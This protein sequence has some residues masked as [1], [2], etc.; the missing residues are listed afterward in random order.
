MKHEQAPLN[1]APNNGKKR[2]KERGPEP[3]PKEQ[4]LK[5][6]IK[7]H[8][9]KSCFRAPISMKKGWKTLISIKPKK[10]LTCNNNVLQDRGNPSFLQ[11]Y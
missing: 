1:K 11:C 10:A 5:W 3:K 2:N 8:W 4:N 9:N 7:G 6:V